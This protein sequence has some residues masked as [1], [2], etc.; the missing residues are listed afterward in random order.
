MSF[1]E[2]YC[3]YIMG[4]RAL[5]S[6]R[7]YLVNTVV[8]TCLDALVSAVSDCLD[9]AGRTR[10]CLSV[11]TRVGY[12]SSGTIHQRLREMQSYTAFMSY[13]DNM[14]SEWMTRD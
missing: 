10:M 9:R 4:L 14:G 11:R 7:K 8:G 12:I 3:F 5:H 1:L 6:S 13:I 2:N